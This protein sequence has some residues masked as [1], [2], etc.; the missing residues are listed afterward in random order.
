MNSLFKITIILNCLKQFSLS[1]NS[2]PPKKV[3]LTLGL[4]P[5]PVS[6]DPSP[7]CNYYYSSNG[8]C[9]NSNQTK[10]YMNSATSFLQLQALNAVSFFALYTNALLYWQIINGWATL[11]S[12]SNSPSILSSLLNLASSVLT[13]IVTWVNTYSNKQPLIVENCFNII[14]NITNGAV[15]I[16]TSNSTANLG[17]ADFLYPVNVPV[18]LYPNVTAVG[19]Q[20]QTCLPLIDTYC[21]LIYGISVFSHSLPFN[22][23]FNFSDGGLTNI[24]C[25]KIQYLINCTTISCNT[26]LN[27]ILVDMFY[28]NWVRF[29]PSAASVASLSAYFSAF[30]NLTAYLSVPSSP[31][32]VGIKLASLQNDF[33]NDFYSAG[34]LSG[35]THAFFGIQIFNCLSFIFLLLV[36][37]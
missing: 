28:T 35:Q 16:L 20:L 23:T 12:D 6:I 33:G 18:T 17:P 25:R 19:G 14:A 4:T 8:S 22:L 7:V 9:V 36:I 30:S 2:C 31:V 11:S 5:L 29:V 10:L 32:G 26:T 21:S 27:G 15:C 37:V 34:L 13:N 3:L 1:S 24:Q